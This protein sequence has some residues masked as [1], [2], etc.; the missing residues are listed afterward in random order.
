MTY[1]CSTVDRTKKYSLK[2][3]VL[4]NIPEEGGLFV[5]AY[6]PK[7]EANFLEELNNLT[8]SELAFKVLKSI[9][10]DQ[11]ELETLR[12]ICNK[13]YSFDVNLVVLSQN[14][15]IG[16]LFHGPTLAFKDF[17]VRFLA[18]LLST[19]IE[20]S[21]QKIILTATSG[22]T[23]GAVADAFY[24]NSKFKVIILFPKNKISKFQQNQICSYRE[25]IISVEVDGNFDYCQK[26][27]KQALNDDSFKEQNKFSSANSI[28]I[29]RLLPQ[30]CYYFRLWSKIPKN[31]CPINFVVPSG[32]FGNITAGIYAKKMG[33]PIGRLIA[34]TNKNDV[35]PRYFNTGKYEISEFYETLST[36]MDIANPNNFPRIQFLYDGNLSEMKKDIFAI[37]VSD[38]DT[39]ETINE[40]FNKYKYQCCPHTAVGVKSAFIYEGNSDDK[41]SLVLG[42]ANPIKFADDN[43]SEISIPNCTI[44]SYSELK[45]IIS[46]A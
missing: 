46:S 6:L 13:A 42:T 30:I 22:D 29:A 7:I 24:R 28:N 36:A 12:K 14:L 18:E 25:N 34:A 41:V 35:V 26:L 37:S 3:A 21:E 11:I 23:G 19:Y 31:H 20:S 43:I 39:R 17:G 40:V 2:E 33:L 38:Q 15:Y 27:A 8:F 9:L 44:K 32:N 1:F 5:P 10:S 16:E 4:S 45:E